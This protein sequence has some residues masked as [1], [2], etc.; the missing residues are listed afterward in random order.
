MPLPRGSEEKSKEKLSRRR[1]LVTG[2]FTEMLLELQAF[3]QDNDSER[4]CPMMGS[5]LSYMLDVAALD[6]K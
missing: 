3:K 6:D 2:K 4:C 1:F 5:F